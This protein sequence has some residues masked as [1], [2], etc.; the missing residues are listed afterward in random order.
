MYDVEIMSMRRRYV[1][2]TSVRRH[3]RAGNLAPRYPKP[4]PPPNILH[5]PTPM[6]IAIRNGRK[7]DEKGLSFL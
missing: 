6:N 7:N 3:V 4:C 2:V 5:L 1:A